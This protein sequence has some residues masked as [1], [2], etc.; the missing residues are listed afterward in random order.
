MLLLFSVLVVL[1]LV[2]SWFGLWVG[3]YNS[4][5]ISMVGLFGGMGF[6]WS[7]GWAWLSCLIF[8]VGFWL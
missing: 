7:D 5:V 4:C 1:G 8:E 3:A 6:D 2:V